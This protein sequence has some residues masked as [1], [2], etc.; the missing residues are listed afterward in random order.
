MTHLRPLSIIICLLAV[1]Y[2]PGAVAASERCYLMVFGSQPHPP[3]IR[4]THTYGTFVRAQVDGPD[5]ATW[6]LDVVTIS[7]MPKSMVLRPLSIIP[8][9]G[10][11]LDLHATFN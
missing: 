1:T 11:N 7:W 10:I 3:Q 9:D 4:Y 8:Q 2:T 6:P 5:P